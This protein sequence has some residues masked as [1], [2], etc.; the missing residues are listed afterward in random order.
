MNGVIVVGTGIAGVRAAEALRASGYAEEI[1]LISQETPIYRP[2][3]SK[4]ALLTPLVGQA[5]MPLKRSAAEFTWL[6]GH[7]VESAD[8]AAKSLVTRTPDGE[9]IVRDFDGLVIASG[10]RSRQLPIPGPTQGRFTLRTLHDAQKLEPHLREGARVVIVG[11]GFIGCE[12]AAAAIARGSYVTVISPEA[13]PLASAIGTELGERIATKH[14]RKG[15]EFILNA[16]VIEFLGTGTVTGLLLDDGTQ[17]TADVVVEA[18]GSLANTEWL[19]GNN[20][21]LANG[22]LTDQFLRAAGTASPIVVCGD[23]ARHPNALFGSS[24]R[25]IEHWTTAGDMGTHAGKTLARLLSGS[26]SECQAFAN[27]P[28]FWSDQYDLQIQSFGI[29]SLGTDIAIIESDAAGNCI[30]EY[31]DATGI[32]GVVGI[33]RTSEIAYYR[34]LL[35]SRS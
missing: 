34:K 27:V 14:R 13:T 23:I 11:S 29:P 1:A 21:D 16:S 8:L 33:N 5:A 28:G 25:R 6:L 15:V 35:N 32:V 20:L 7:Q 3:V 4:E 22:V 10:L 17:I 2:A 30:A 9:I 31:R 26:E 12:V 19:V 18:V 24:V